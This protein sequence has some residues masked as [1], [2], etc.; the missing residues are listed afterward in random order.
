VVATPLF[1]MGKEQA[2][3]NEQVKEK[4]ALDRAW[5]QRHISLVVPP[6]RGHGVV[7]ATCLPASE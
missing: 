2:V 3:A 7:Q 1:Y 5:K 4:A 6:R